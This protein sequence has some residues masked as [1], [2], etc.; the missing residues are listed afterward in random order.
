MLVNSWDNGKAN[1]DSGLS[2]RR[3]FTVLS[4]KIYFRL[5]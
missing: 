2:I 5:I 1:S 4:V 3:I